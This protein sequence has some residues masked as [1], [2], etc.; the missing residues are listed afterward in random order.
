MTKENFE[1]WSQRQDVI[2][3]DDRRA[4]H[5]EQPGIDFGVSILWSHTGLGR[6]PSET[7]HRLD[8]MVLENANHHN[9]REM[10]GDDAYDLR[11]YKFLMV[12]KHHPNYAIVY[13]LEPDWTLGVFRV[14]M[15]EEPQLG[16]GLITEEEHEGIEVSFSTRM[17]EMA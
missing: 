1:H 8:V 5:L 10:A 3:I 6:N 15:V 17:I 7:A 12:N 11:K 14:K 13:K 16:D 9:F 2:T 4:V